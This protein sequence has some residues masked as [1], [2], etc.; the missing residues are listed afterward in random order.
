M[1]SFR[2][3][4]PAERALYTV[5]RLWL[6][7]VGLFVV[8]AIVQL[9]AA[10]LAPWIAQ[11]THQRWRLG[12][13]EGTLWQGRASVYGLDR[14]SG[15]WHPG[16][17]MRWRLVVSELLPGLGGLGRLA[18]QVDLDEG[19]GARLAAGIRG[20][21]IERLDAMLSAD[22]IAALLPGTLG[23]YGWSGTMRGRGAEFRCRWTRP[24]C[25]GQVELTWEHAAVAQIPG[26]PLGDYLLR[27][28][29]EGEALRFDLTTVR[30]RLQIT[31][32]GE[33]SAG[34]LHFA[35]EAA[36]TG[37]NATGL[38]TILRT[39]GRPGTAPGRYLIEYREILR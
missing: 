4:N 11:A 8:A 30:G 16:R 32:A 14:P 22:Q 39:I 28:T 13:V 23:D 5:K 17:G 21:S 25:T 31:G 1:P 12:A 24:E 27:L 33:L 35:G 3:R 9:P 2:C 34:T 26:P 20:W 10:W 19:G 15:R 18:V 37:E 6:F 7:G 36:A 38:D 29:A